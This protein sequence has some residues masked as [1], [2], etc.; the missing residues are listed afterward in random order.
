MLFTLSQSADISPVLHCLLAMPFKNSADPQ[1]TEVRMHHPGYQDCDIAKRCHRIRQDLLGRSVQSSLDRQLKDQMH[2]KQRAIEKARFIKRV[3]IVLSFVFCH[4]FGRDARHLVSRNNKCKTPSQR[5]ANSNAKFQII[6]D[7]REVRIA[8]Y[9]GGSPA[10]D[11][12][13]KI[14][15]S[16]LVL[17]NGRCPEAGRTL[18]S[19]ALFRTRYRCLQLGDI[20]RVTSKN[21]RSSERHADSVSYEY[22][23]PQTPLGNK[24]QST[25]LW[26][27]AQLANSNAKLWIIPGRGK[28]RTAAHAGTAPAKEIH[29][30]YLPSL[31]SLMSGRRPEA[32]CYLPSDT[33]LGTQY[34]RLQ[35]GALTRVTS[36]DRA[37]DERCVDYLSYEN[38]KPTHLQRFNAFGIFYRVGRVLCF[39]NGSTTRAVYKL[40]KTSCTKSITNRL[41]ILYSWITAQL[42]P[43]IAQ[44]I[45]KPIVASLKLSVRIISSISNV[46]FHS[47]KR[48][49]G[50]IREEEG[51][52]PLPIHIKRRSTLPDLSASNQH[53]L[54][55]KRTSHSAF[56][57]SHI[58]NNNADYKDAGSSRLQAPL[59]N[60]YL[61]A[62]SLSSAV[63]VEKLRGISG[64]IPLL[65]LSAS[66]FKYLER[67]SFLQPHKKES[68]KRW[69][70]WLL[71][72]WPSLLCSS[73]GSFSFPVQ[74][75]KLRD[76]RPFIS[77]LR[78]S[79]PGYTGLVRLSLCALMKESRRAGLTVSL[80]CVFLF[81]V[82]PYSFRSLPNRQEAVIVPFLKGLH[83]K[84]RALFS[85][86]EMLHA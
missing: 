30:E 50:G 28:L 40:L 75:K 85:A 84:R 3:S 37:P 86:W 21:G 22:S 20:T 36:R 35:L 17:K 38:D 12:L 8:A 27:F 39:Q 24:G 55:H 6:L 44:T 48:G 54:W 16:L 74:R 45:K 43:R 26:G 11:S 9:A 46:S 83:I 81:L 32:G 69:P 13:H 7:R 82:F 58:S 70:K 64:F 19:D 62:G 66:N 23:E 76:A 4:R 1:W 33:L 78:L 77:P 5:P 79:D 71:L 68:M 56:K 80:P 42:N 25:P 73:P 63:L 67:F 14:L 29:H 52:V 59:K 53:K 2:R 15:P 49:M 51:R 31:G 34:W 10:K 57:F 61:S 65:L 47:L 41:A 18:P 72:F 60:R